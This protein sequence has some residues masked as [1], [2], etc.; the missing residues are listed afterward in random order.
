M[1]LTRASA[2][3]VT[4]FLFFGLVSS[5]FAETTYTVRGGD[6]MWDIATQFGVSVSDLS[7]ANGIANP[8][9]IFVGQKLRMPDETGT[10]ASAPSASTEQQNK[11]QATVRPTPPSAGPGSILAKQ[12]VISYYGNPYTGQ[13][14]VLGR[15]DAD[16]MVAKL[17]QQAAEYAARS[18]RPV[19]PALQMVAI[20]A[21]AGAG[22]D[23]MYRAKMPDSVIDEYA[24]LAER[25]DMLF[26]LDLQVGRSSVQ[27]EVNSVRKFLERPYVHLALDPEFD[28]GPSQM[29][30]QQ[31]G[32]TDARHINWAIDELSSIVAANNLPTKILIVHQFMESMITNKTAIKTDPNVDVVI[33]MDGFGGQAA[34]ISKYNFVQSVPVQFAGI[35]LFY[36]EDVDLMTPGQVMQLKPIPDMVIYQ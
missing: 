33:D 10:A 15:Y 5:A 2:A 28:M 11:P 7:R 8:D 18:D 29:P 4:A 12:L 32:S 30:G 27:N 1:R 13:M 17:K 6:T 14:G 19:K 21:Q 34:K 35:K 24:K 22:A 31:I 16:A 26:I 9:L 20:V 3:I 23:G 36:R 25:N